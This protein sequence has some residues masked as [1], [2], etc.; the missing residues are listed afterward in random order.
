MTKN[1]GLGKASAKLIIMGEH[2]V[3]PHCDANGESHPGSSALAVP[4]PSLTTRVK[5][6]RTQEFDCTLSSGV[7][8]IRF[9]ADVRPMMLKAVRLCADQIRWDLQREPIRVESETNFA[10]SRGLGSSAAFSVALVQAFQDLLNQDFNV[11]AEAQKIENLFHGRSSGLDTAVISKG[12]PIL[13]RDGRIISNFNPS[14]VDF[15][16]VDSGPRE[17]CS[18]L[19]SKTLDL[20]QKEPKLWSE[21]TMRVERCI[22]D[23]LS[24]IEK[25]DGATG[26]AQ[27]VTEVQN[28]LREVGLMNEQ[29]ESVLKLGMKQG[30]LAGKM[31]GAGAGGAVL[32]V[33]ARGDG[34]GL[35]TRM[36][37]EGAQVVAVA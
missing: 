21:L 13:F 32:F 6:E 23:C 14:A 9:D 8:A 30:A 2:F 34:L 12:K 28:I 25:I 1:S 11:P 22:Q 18:T 7:S 27:S 10:P 20:R 5:I 3:V 36:I 16:V 24:A 35:A 37:Q 17:S 31:S 15:V 33:T 29:M 26:V 4:L 19:V